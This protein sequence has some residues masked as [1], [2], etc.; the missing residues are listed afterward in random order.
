MKLILPKKKEQKTPSETLEVLFKD[1]L[2]R[3]N[4]EYVEGCLDWVSEAH[5]ELLR[6]AQ[7][8]ERC[9]DMAWV[10]ILAGKPALADYERAVETWHQVH[11]RCFEMYEK[12]PKAEQGKLF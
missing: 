9:I 2:D 5:P 1:K 10:D 6:K 12:R 4:N 3:L 7:E 8:A 11:K